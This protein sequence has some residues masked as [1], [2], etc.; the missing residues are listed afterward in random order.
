VEATGFDPLGY[1]W[2]LDNEPILGADVDTYIIDSTMPEDLGEYM[3]EITD[4]CDQ[5]VF[6]DS[7]GLIFHPPVEIVD[8]PVGGEFCV[9]DQVT[10][11]VIDS[12]GI[13]YQWFKDDAEIDGATQFFLIIDSAGIDDS[14]TY[15]VDI[16]GECD[17][18]TS[19]DAVVNVIECEP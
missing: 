16:F 9:G 12:G 15:R 1:Q 13:T 6:S 17:A 19:D 11:F 14:G 4:A 10:L 18:T 2:F 8:Q 7:A 3:C 5:S